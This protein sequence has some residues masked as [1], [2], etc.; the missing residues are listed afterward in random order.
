VRS[1][2]GRGANLRSQPDRASPPVGALDNGA[3]VTILDG[4]VSDARGKMWYRVATDA[5]RGY[6][7]A[8]LLTSPTLPLG[9][10]I[11]APFT[12]T[13][14]EIGRVPVLMYHNVN[15]SGNRYSVTPEQLAAQCAW[16]HDHGY[17]TIALWQLVDAAFNGGLLPAK[18][19]VLT[20]DD[21]WAS[22]LDFAAILSEYGL[23]GNYFVNN[24][25]ELTPDQIAYLANV[26]EVEAHTANHPMMS[27]LD[28]ATQF[29]EIAD[30]RAYLEDVTGL[31]VEYLAWP[32]G[33]S[34]P[35]AVQ[36][37]VDAG[38]VA[39]F[40]AVGG[41]AILTNLDRYHIP[42]IEIASYHD[43]DAFAARVTTER[44]VDGEP[45]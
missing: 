13:A 7:R 11:G 10:S 34:N 6:V 3:T 43:L 22:A 41:P 28:Y 1:N 31:P 38:I 29:A 23:I 20:A 8:D 14:A 44:F 26:G 42:R 21:G 5:L 25:S 12:Y 35:S 37:A 15:Y 30:N 40:D 32:Y 33:D 16:L 45:A 18:P 19:V 4:P 2:D 9:G 36:A 24:A 27:R 39:A 17:T